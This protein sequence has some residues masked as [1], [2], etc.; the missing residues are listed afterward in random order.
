MAGRHFGVIWT[1]VLNYTWCSFFPLLLNLPGTVSPSRSVNAWGGRQQQVNDSNRGFKDLQKNVHIQAEK[2]AETLHKA[3][4]LIIQSFSKKDKLPRIS[5]VQKDFSGSPNLY[6]LYLLYQQQSGGLKNG[7]FPLPFHRRPDKK[8]KFDFN[9]KGNRLKRSTKSDHPCNQFG[10]EANCSKCGF[11]GICAPGTSRIS[12][13]LEFSLRTQRE[14]QIDVPINHAQVLGSHNAYNN[15]A[16]GYGDLDDCHWPLKEN[17][18]CISLAN[19][20]F[21]FTDQLNMG[22]RFFE[23]DLWHC[24]GDVRM[25]HANLKLHVGCA[26][27]DRKLGEG[28][29]EFAD[30]MRKPRNRDEVIQL[31][32]EDHTNGDN[33]LINNIIGKYFGDLVLTPSDLKT[34]FDGR[35]PTTRQMRQVNKSVVITD[36]ANNHNGR[37]LHGITWKK[38]FTVNAFRTHPGTCSRENPEETMRVYSD[39]T[40][41]GPFW[42]GDKETGTV[43]DFKEFLLCG[44]TIPCA[45]QINFELMKTAVFTW[46]DGEPNRAL[47]KESCVVLS[48][49][50][51][52]HVTNCTERHY[53]A[54][55]TNKDRNQWNISQDSGP[56]HSPTCHEGQL[57]SV[58]QNGYQHKRLEVA[59]EGKTVWLNL[60]PFI[61]LL[62]TKV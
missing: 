48:R 6:N 28:M 17:E 46:A 47:T 10:K 18:V 40:S 30:W 13:W 31:F 39:S 60:T 22:V 21:S 54:C 12:P 29:K 62:N 8:V 37:Y 27:W 61:H 49:D 15:R 35:W 57:F 2:D 50:R 26:P 53:F 42:N 4:E 11:H 45:D 59:S 44:I 23:I 38:G 25:S 34:I 58:P 14:L 55:V 3:A 9:L 33:D 1:A 20:E 43:L 5:E 56:Y 51:R 41:Y 7:N 36:G 52:W 16:S 24:F 32:F 19:Q